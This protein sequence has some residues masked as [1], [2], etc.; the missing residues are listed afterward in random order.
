MDKRVS[1]FIKLYP[2]YKGLEADLLFY[3]AVDSMFLAMTKGFTD[4]E[5]VSL[6]TVATLS[7]LIL[8]F[9]LL[10]LVHRIGNTGTM[11]F[12]AVC[13]LLSATFITFGQS[14]AVVA[15]GRIFHEVAIICSA[16]SA[17][18]ALENSLEVA[19]Q[20]EDFVRVRSNGN[21]V[22]AVFTMIIALVA[23]FMFNYNNYLP[24]YCCIG[25]HVI[26]LIVTFC[27]A[28]ATPYNKITRKKKA[29]AK[30]AKLG[31]AILLL[32]LTYGIFYALINAG[33][34]DGKLFFQ[35][36]LLLDFDKENTTLIISLVVV[37]SRVV[38][39]L[40]NL[41]FPAIYKKLGM[42]TTYILPACLALS[43]CMNLFGSFIPNVIA[44]IAVMGTAYLIILFIRDPYGI[45]TQDMLLKS[46]PKEQ[47]QTAIT[48]LQFATKLSVAITSLSFSFILLSFPLIAEMAILCVLGAA[49]II[50]CYVLY[51]MLT[52]KHDAHEEEEVLV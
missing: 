30:K 31:P 35:N 13:M 25:A 52:A 48:L 41:V 43:L 40:A 37:I 1:R 24:M 6:T 14:F 32:L 19:G 33:Q 16:A 21:T 27:M 28:D 11:R 8:Q 47:H 20:Q 49:E 44:K 3:V 5:Y 12:G 39:V 7:F 45:S 17:I 2:L 26:G 38:R 46:T 22:Y 36:N 9:P 10:W 18:V 23:G 34:L 4:A 29:A 15:I 51:R 42:R 50:C